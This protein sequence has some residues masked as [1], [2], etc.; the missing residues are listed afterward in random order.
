MDS[1]SHSPES[2]RTKAFQE[3]NDLADK[4]RECEGPD[5]ESRA[6]KAYYLGLVT[7]KA[8][9]YMQDEILN[10]DESHKLIQW[11]LQE[12]EDDRILEGG[13]PHLKKDNTG[14]F[15][16][17]GWQGRKVSGDRRMLC[18]MASMDLWCSDKERCNI[19]TSYENPQFL[20]MVT[21][22]FVE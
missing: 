18:D 1:I 14:F 7:G 17:N 22:E 12:R 3:L 16:G 4:V 2:L 19:C 13:C 11:T 5:K 8:I 21:Q 20:D 9:Q 10:A 15:C 6:R